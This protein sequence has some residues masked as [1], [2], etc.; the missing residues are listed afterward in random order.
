MP[1][2]FPAAGA[3]APPLGGM[4]DL[5]AMMRDPA[6]MQ[7][8]QQMMGGMG[9]GAPGANPAADPM[10]QMMGNPA[11][12]Q[13]MMQGMDGWHGWRSSGGEPRGRPHAADD[14]QPCNDAGHDA[15][16]GWVAWVAELRGRTPRPT[17]CSR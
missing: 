6:M 15:G 9:G 7:A 8:M 12:M 10:Q 3:G 13:A 4:P 16:N 5:G 17:P 2:P 11:M 1:P 14:G